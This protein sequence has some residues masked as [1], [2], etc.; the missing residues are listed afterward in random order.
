MKSDYCFIIIIMISRFLEEEIR[1]L[2]IRRQESVLF[3]LFFLD[4]HHSVFVVAACLREDGVDRC[5]NGD[6]FLRSIHVSVKPLFAVV[7][8]ERFREVVICDQTLLEGLGVIVRSLNQR[9][10]SHVV[11]HRFLW[12]I[13][14]LVIRSTAGRMDEATRDAAD[15]Q[16]IVDAELYDG[17]QFCLSPVQHGVQ[18]LCLSDVT[19]KAVEQKS[20]SAF[21]STEVVIDEI[22]DQLVGHELAVVHHLLDRLPD[23]RTGRHLG[24]QHVTG[25]KVT[26]AV[27]L[28]QQWCLRALSRAGRTEQ[29][30]IDPSADNVYRQLRFL[31]NLD[32]CERSH[33]LSLKSFFFIIFTRKLS[34]KCTRH[35]SDV[36][37]IIGPPF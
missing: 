32:L 2:C 26:N 34:G 16:R 35:H 22:D 4:K 36:D 9:L 8:H 1:V 30:S 17:V 37:S 23:G 19:R 29:N 27:L 31:G 33:D 20:V 13:K 14:F 3:L 12:C 7:I 5:E 25:G 6:R 11:C 24:T 21:G 10:T 18:L 15:Q 28:S